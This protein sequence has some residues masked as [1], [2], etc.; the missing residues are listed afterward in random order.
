MDVNTYLN[1]ILNTKDV[2]NLLETNKVYYIK[3]KD[4]IKENCLTY[5]I[6]REKVGYSEDLEEKLTKYTIQIDILSNS[7]YSALLKI[8]KDKFKKEQWI[9]EEIVDGWDTDFNYH[10]ILRYSFYLNY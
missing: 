5:Y 2:T 4:K 9:K 6:L 7:N 3:T 8:L 1:S 10:K